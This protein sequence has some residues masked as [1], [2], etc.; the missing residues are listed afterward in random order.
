MIFK[1]NSDEFISYLSDASNYKG[2]ADE[3]FIPESYYEL[4]RIIEECGKIN[5][6]ITIRGGGTSTTGSSVPDGGIIISM[7]K[8]NKVI[9]FDL[10]NKT[11]L[12]QS[13]IS[14]IDLENY[15]SPFELYL[16]VDPTEKNATIGGNIS[17]NASGAK[18]YKYGSIYNH[19]EQIALCSLSID[20]AL[21]KNTY[22]IDNT[23]TKTTLKNAS[24]YN[25]ENNYGYLFGSEGTL[26]VIED[27]K[28]KLTDKP[29]NSLMFM[30]FFE[31]DNE[32]LEALKV[33]KNL[34]NIENKSPAYLDPCLIEYFDKA[35]LTLLS[36]GIPNIPEQANCALWLEQECSN[37]EIDDLLDLWYDFLSKQ[38]PLITDTI[39]FIDPASK[40]K[41][42]DMRH[43]IPEY[44]NEKI[45]SINTFKIASDTAVPDD[46][47]DEHYR[48]ICNLVKNN[49]LESYTFGHIGNSH[50][51]CN[52][53][54]KCEN[55]VLL[56]K[57]IIDAINLNAI[58][59]NG[60]ISAEHG[61]GKLKNQYFNRMIN[62]EKLNKMKDVKNKFDPNFIF[63]NGNIF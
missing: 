53:I 23:N 15:L 2:I 19:I 9:D 57:K 7:E 63:G 39:T 54:P 18:S 49:N 35:S 17:T 33:I 36:R 11:I 34:N 59:L 41:F 50:L 32:M 14:L 38:I 6:K 46:C 10:G 27:V 8:L 1:N 31:D 12:V 44:I 61:I 56:A 16:P 42:I 24:G 48:F 52:F 28:I 3:L 13:G 60:T 26:G 55:E 5:E 58:S 25:L 20:K 22:N 40:R 47:F 4:E 21:I 51:H 43:S 45:S 30:V 29:E 62:Q 37:K